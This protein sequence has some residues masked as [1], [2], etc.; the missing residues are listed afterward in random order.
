MEKEAAEEE[1]GVGCGGCE[2]TLRR[3]TLWWRG[4]GCA[5]AGCCMQ[6]DAAA[7]ENARCV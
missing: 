4:A 5:G 7:A 2:R 3:K 1:E 6:Q